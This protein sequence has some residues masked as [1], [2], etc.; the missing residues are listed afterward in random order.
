[1]EERVRCLTS[2][3]NKLLRIYLKIYCFIVKFHT[4]P[5]SMLSGICNLAHILYKVDL[6]TNLE[7]DS[8]GLVEGC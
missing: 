3:S 8:G 1:M 6:G 2:V 7:R 4:D 5:Y